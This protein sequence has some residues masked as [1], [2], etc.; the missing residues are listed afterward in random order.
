MGNIFNLEQKILKSSGTEFWLAQTH[1]IY[2]F[3]LLVYIEPFNLLYIFTQNMVEL[4]EN[5]RW[6]NL[7]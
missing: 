1:L 6:A 2:L 5:K 3:G 7:K 4:E